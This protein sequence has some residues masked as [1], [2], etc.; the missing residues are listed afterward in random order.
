MESSHVLKM[1]GLWYAGGGGRIPSIL[2]FMAPKWEGSMLAAVAIPKHTYIS[3][4]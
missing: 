3:T 2:A 4:G 1:H